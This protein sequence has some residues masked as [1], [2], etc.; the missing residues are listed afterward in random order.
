MVG[1]CQRHSS[2]QGDLPYSEILGLRDA[3]SIFM[4]IQ[5]TIQ[6]ELFYLPPP[7]LERKIW[8]SDIFKKITIYNDRITTMKKFTN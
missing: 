6:S 7:E 8:R 1:M 5:T 4:F 3:F 2:E